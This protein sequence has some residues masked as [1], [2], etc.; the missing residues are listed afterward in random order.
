M[1]GNEAQHDAEWSIRLYR[2][3]DIPALVAL[4]NAVSAT[5]DDWQMTEADYERMYNQP[6]RDPQR[7]VVV[8][9]G[10]LPEGLPTGA[11]LGTGRAFPIE[12][13]ETNECVYELA[14]RVHPS[15]RDSL[16]ER[17][18]ARELL[19]IV[20]SEE[21]RKR[22][23]G[24]VLPGRRVLVRAYTFDSSTNGIALWR[25]LGM[26]E[27]RR[28]YWMHRTTSDPILEPAAVE[29]VSFHTYRKPD[30]NAGVRQAALASFADHY[31]FNKD[32]FAQEWQHWDNVDTLRPELSW[33][34][35]GDNT[36]QIVSVCIVDVGA[37]KNKETGAADA[38]ITYVGTLREWRGRGLAR[39]LLLRSLQSLREAGVEDVY[40]N[41][42]ASSATGANH[43]YELVG[44]SVKQASSQYE[45]EVQN[46][47]R[48]SQ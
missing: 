39:N 36:R 47:R 11:L 6:G 28:W 29:G 21:E 12:N 10:P 40:L 16:T 13:T 38:L 34:A 18:T 22:E 45:C 46:V 33:V 3:G 35:E 9:D 20:D 42:D 17:D 26:Q 37:V 31:D 24:V 27:E 2:Q 25:W 19:A 41:V 15:L 7:H 30:D 5:T 23:E 32:V 14:F 48:A 4:A 8:V 43:L 1:A 44:Y